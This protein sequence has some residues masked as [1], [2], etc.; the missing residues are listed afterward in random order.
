MIRIGQ[1]VRGAFPSRPWHFGSCSDTRPLTPQ[2]TQ[3]RRFPALLVPYAAAIIPA[4]HVSRAN[5]LVSPRHAASIPVTVPQSH[6][7]AV[8]GSGWDYS[9]SALEIF[10]PMKVKKPR[11]VPCP[12]ALQA[13]MCPALASRS[14]GRPVEA[15]RIGADGRAQTE[16]NPS[17][18]L[19]LR[20][21]WLRKMQC[22]R[23]M[24]RP[25]GS[26][27]RCPCSGLGWR[28]I[29]RRECLTRRPQQT[30]P[31][32][33][34]I[35]GAPDDRPPREMDGRG[36][37]RPR[38]PKQGEWIELAARHLDPGQGVR[39]ERGP[40]QGQLGALGRATESSAPLAATLSKSVDR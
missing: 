39:G 3:G 4:A 22:Q 30:R 38:A 21:A 23:R 32:G 8:C 27:P 15:L 40:W 2:P 34:R 6:A 9:M 36:G 19:T 13:S 37:A 20:L 33:G 11:A 5:E 18:A 7:V 24:L 16:L 17:G 31:C 26:A 10:R 28:P 35:V 12:V 25:W 14:M 29:A 1:Y